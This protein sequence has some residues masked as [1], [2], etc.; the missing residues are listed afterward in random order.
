L[1]S[2]DHF[3]YELVAPLRSAAAQG[4]AGRP[5]IESGGQK[6]LLTEGG[7]AGVQR[8]CSRYQFSA[9]PGNRLGR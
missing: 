5:D 2:V 4:A 9:Y 1:V 3:K 7:I 8:W 6:A